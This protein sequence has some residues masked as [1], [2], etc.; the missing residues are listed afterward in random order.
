MAAKIPLQIITHEAPNPGFDRDICSVRCVPAQFWDFV[1]FFLLVTRSYDLKKYVAYLLQ[2]KRHIDR[3]MIDRKKKW[4]F[5]DGVGGNFID[6][7]A[8]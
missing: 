8:F 3:K 7:I 1:F 6:K 4:F 2:D 5:T